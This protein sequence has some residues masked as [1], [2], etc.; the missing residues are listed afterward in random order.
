M[1]P[2]AVMFDL[3]GTLLDTLADIAD[4]GNH[5][6]AAMGREPY[7]VSRYRHLAGQGVRSL[8][9]DALGEQGPF[10]DDDVARGIEL[11]RAYYADHKYDQTGPYPRV[12]ELLDTLIARGMTLAIL[13]NKPDD[14]TRE[15]VDRLLG[16]ASFQVI[17]GHCEPAPLKPDPQAALAIAEGLGIAPQQWL[18]VGDTKVDME[19]AVR[20]GM[21]PVGVTWGFRD[22]DELRANGA[23][24]IIHQPMELMQRLGERG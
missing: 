10:D 14:A 23:R 5:A 6:M 22:E 4:A 9:V 13:S 24:T 19:T 20:S 1:N 7:P 2:T 3:D 15:V 18:F 17:R 8:V 21:W 16:A 11:F 12:M